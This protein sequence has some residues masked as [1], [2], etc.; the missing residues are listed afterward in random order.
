MRRKRPN[1]WLEIQKLFRKIKLLL[2]YWTKSKPTEKVYYL[3][4][5]EVY[6][7]QEQHTFLFSTKMITSCR[8]QPWF[9][10]ISFLIFQRLRKNCSLIR[11][12]TKTLDFFCPISYNWNQFTNKIY[13]SR[14]LCCLLPVENTINDSSNLDTHIC[15]CLLRQHADKFLPRR[16]KLEPYYVCRVG[17]SI[18]RVMKCKVFLVWFP[19]L[20]YF[21][22]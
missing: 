16:K 18:F 15:P 17:L 9:R 6:L 21:L 11:Y 7:E 13:L 1:N 14:R 5:T 3:Y 12:T 20:N 2:T 19:H 4:Q 10:K 8:F 22:L